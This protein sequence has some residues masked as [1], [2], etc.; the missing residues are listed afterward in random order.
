MA[1]S[2]AM[3]NGCISWTRASS[4]G[5]REN[6]ILVSNIAGGTILGVLRAYNP[7]DAGLILLT[8]LHGVRAL[9]LHGRGSWRFLMWLAFGWCLL[10]RRLLGYVGGHL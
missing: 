10:S 4:I 1:Q 9:N 7:I 6:L 3:H 8:N 2:R 5:R